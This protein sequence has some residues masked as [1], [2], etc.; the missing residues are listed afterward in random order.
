MLLLPL[1]LAATL[2]VSFI[3][4]W[5]LA[6][7][8]STVARPRVLVHPILG[9]SWAPTAL[10][11]LLA[12]VS[13][14]CVAVTLDAVNIPPGG[15]LDGHAVRLGIF[16]LG[17]WTAAA[18]GVLC[19]ALVAGTIGGFIVRKYPAIAALLTFPIAWLVAMSTV[20]YLP[21]LLHQDVGFVYT[22]MD[23]C[24]VWSQ[25]SDPASGLGWVGPAVW[26]LGWSP[27]YEPFPF[28]ALMIGV[29]AWAR[30][31]RERPSYAHHVPRR[32]PAA[33]PNWPIDS[34]ATGTS[35]SDL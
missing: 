32:S 5:A 29:M 9:G 31:L 1:V 19:A 8:E 18:G 11:V 25:S 7:D 34:L 28:F 30:L 3:A 21:W 20:P 27:Y 10:A 6:P 15:Y 35:E 12:L 24:S 16:D 13:L 23:V 22:C 33:A 4:R 14:P 2:V 17:R 26:L